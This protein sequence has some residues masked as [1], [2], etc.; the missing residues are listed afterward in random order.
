MNR[1]RR[2]TLKAEKKRLPALEAAITTLT[3]QKVKAQERGLVHAERI[4]NVGLY[5]LLMDKDFAVLKVDMVSTCENWRLKHTARQMWDYCSMK[6]VTTSPICLEKI[7]EHHLPRWGAKVKKSKLLTKPAN[8]STN[9][10]TRTMN[11][12]IKKF[13]T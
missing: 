7:L 5:L 4:Y 6:C 13:G 10:R 11:F 3:E 2:R 12:F 1:N 8:D 9:S